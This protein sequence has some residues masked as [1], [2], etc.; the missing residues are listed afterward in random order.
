MAIRP[1]RARRLL[2]TGGSGFLGRHIVNGLASQAWEVIAPSSA[3]LDLRNGES[4]RQAVR[5][6]KPTAIIHTAYRHPD[7]TSIVDA[8]RHVADAAERNKSRLVHLS[9]D[10][11]FPGRLA[12]Y[13]ERDEPRPVHQ[14]GHDKADA[15][16]IVSATFP[17]SVIVRTSLMVGG[18]VLS[19]HEQL[20]MD[21]IAGRTDIK[22]FTDEIR[23]P[24]LVDELA[25]ALCSL[26]E[27]SEIHGI[28][29]IGGPEPLSRADLALLIAHHHGLDRTRLRFDSI[30]DSGLTRP[31]RVVLDST[32][33]SDLGVVVRGPGDWR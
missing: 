23:S 16:R 27:R 31:S 12:P 15:E 13:T 6:W 32:M 5:D 2:V 9:T 22:F 24:L 17:N 18:S 29:H 21:A 30:E 8:T 7:R 26:A 20:V 14:Y 1:K 4:V 25:T 33:A 11:I 10:A 19:Q 28:L 3:S